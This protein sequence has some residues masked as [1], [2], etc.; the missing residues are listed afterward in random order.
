LF[1]EQLGL[2]L[3]APD[4]LLP[5]MRLANTVAKERAAELLIRVDEWFD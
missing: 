1:E 3:H 4:D 2:I 5:E